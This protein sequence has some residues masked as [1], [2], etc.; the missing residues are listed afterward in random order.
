MK[1]SWMK[2]LWKSVALGLTSVLAAGIFAGC[3]GGSEQAGNMKTLKVGVTNFADTLDPLENYFAWVVVRY[4][5]GENLTKFDDKMGAT[6][7]LAESWSVADDKLTWTFQI[8]DGV[9]FLE[10]RSADG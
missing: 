8:R 6:P 1:K 10:W 4:G 9:K 7:W 2:K 3:G 5:L